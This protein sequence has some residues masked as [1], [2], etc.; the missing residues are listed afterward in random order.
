MD[1]IAR[2]AHRRLRRLLALVG[3]WSSTECT[4]NADPAEP[5]AR[6]PLAHPDIARMSERERADL[7]FDP[8]TIRR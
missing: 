2:L 5:W 7:P 6:D 8:S 3:K 1:A 4:G